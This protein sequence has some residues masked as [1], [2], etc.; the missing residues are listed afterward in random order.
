MNGVPNALEVPAL[1]EEL[2]ELIFGMMSVVRI[3]SD[4]AF[5]LVLYIVVFVKYFV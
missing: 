5:C 1:S 3:C 2:I 4:V